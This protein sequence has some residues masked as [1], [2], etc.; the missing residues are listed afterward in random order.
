MKI[1]SIKSQ[2]VSL[3]VDEPLAGG[4]PSG[5]AH[6]LFVTVRIE[7]PDAIEGVGAAFFGGALS[8]TLKQAI[9]QLGQMIIGED[10]LRGEAI[11]QKLR[12]A[13]ASAGPGG[14]L[15]L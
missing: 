13:G 12:A 1:K 15:T 10:P 2:V 14:I 5:R 3:P 7:T 8:A 4:P 9:D 6:N 11:L